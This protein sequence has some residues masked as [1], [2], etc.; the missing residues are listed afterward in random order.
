[1]I[2]SNQSISKMQNFYMDTDSFINH[3]KTE[4][5]YKDI[6]GNGEKKIDTSN[7]EVNRS[8]ATGTN[9]KSNWINER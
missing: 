9:K 1:M 8:L 7:Y 4:D 2:I 5:V 3:I 6:A